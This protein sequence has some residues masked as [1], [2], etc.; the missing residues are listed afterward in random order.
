MVMFFQ[1]RGLNEG[2]RP[3][4]LAVIV[5]CIVRRAAK[6]CQSQGSTHS[7]RSSMQAARRGRREPWETLADAPRRGS[8]APGSRRPTSALAPAAAAWCLPPSL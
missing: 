1:V 3:G 6:C 2:H 5:V 4:V 8:R 7:Q